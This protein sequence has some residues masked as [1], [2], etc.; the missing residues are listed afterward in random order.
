MGS[1]ILSRAGSRQ[2][3]DI[4]LNSLENKAESGLKQIFRGGQ[5]GPFI[6]LLFISD[7]TTSKLPTPPKGR[8]KSLCAP[9]R[10]NLSGS[11]TKGGG[12]GSELKNHKN[13]PAGSVPGKGNC[14]FYT[15]AQWRGPKAGLSTVKLAEIVLSVSVNTDVWAKAC[16]VGAPGGARSTYR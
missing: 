6:L 10:W 12:F 7:N 9:D 11:S 15:E 8:C 3:A 16:T 5:K 14:I 2:L 13:A 1:P 4:K